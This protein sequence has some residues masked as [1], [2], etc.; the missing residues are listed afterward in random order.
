MEVTFTV[1]AAQLAWMIQIEAHE[2]TKTSWK[3]THSHLFSYQCA[4]PVEPSNATDVTAAEF[5]APLPAAPGVAPP[6]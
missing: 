3:N 1:P 4:H 6:W 5:G 2:K